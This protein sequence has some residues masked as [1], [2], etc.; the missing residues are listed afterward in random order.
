M[1][2]L[3]SVLDPHGI[4]LYPVKMFCPECGEQ[5]HDEGDLGKKAHTSH[6]CLKCGRIWKVPG[7]K[8]FVGTVRMNEKGE[9]C[10]S[11]TDGI[12]QLADKQKLSCNWSGGKPGER[13]RC[14]LCGYKFVLHDYFRWV[15]TN[16]LSDGRYGGNPLVCFSCDGE[17]VVERWK[18]LCDEYYS[19]KFWRFREDQ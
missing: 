5:H 2:A 4:K 15:Y 6:V 10:T 19:D 11:F 1:A 17:D 8:F 12:A 14:A 3:V 7:N 18:K 16:G 13:F 9:S